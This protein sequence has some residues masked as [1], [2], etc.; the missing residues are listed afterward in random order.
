MPTELF[1]TER[2]NLFR[3]SLRRYQRQAPGRECS[4]RPPQ[5]SHDASVVIV[6]AT[7]SPGVDVGAEYDGGAADDLPHD[8]PRWPMR[9]D[10]CGAELLPGSRWQRWVSRLYRTPDGAL[11]V[12]QDLPPGAVY[13]APW[14]ASFASEHFKADWAGKRQPLVV[15]CPDGTPWCIDTDASNGPGWK[16]TGEAP[17]LT[18]RPSILVPGYHGWLTDGVLSDPI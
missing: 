13:E 7:D 4:G 8:D 17:K 2:T 9:C 12:T 3:V 11:Y 10:H 14:Y 16:V 18:A 15:V 5:A 6:E 1:M